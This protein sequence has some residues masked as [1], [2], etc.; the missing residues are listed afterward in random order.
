MFFRLCISSFGL[1]LIAAN[2]VSHAQLS[3][4]IPYIHTHTYQ[5]VIVFLCY[6]KFNNCF[7]CVKLIGPQAWP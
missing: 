5:V 6:F 7:H 2:V 4:S 1:T 3:S